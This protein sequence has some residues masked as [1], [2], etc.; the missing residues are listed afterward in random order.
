MWTWSPSLSKN[1]V[2]R[3]L[4]LLLWC[5]EMIKCLCDE[6]KLGEWH[7][8]CDALLGYYLPSYDRS[9]GRSSALVDLGPYSHDY[10][11]D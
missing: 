8:L 7:R 2:M 3:S 5:C 9:E 10:V 6:M 11:N 4:F 1:I